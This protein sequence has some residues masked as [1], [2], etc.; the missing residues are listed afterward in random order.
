MSRIGI[1][2]GNGKFPFLALQGARSLGH[3]VTVVAV[4]VL[5]AEMHSVR[6]EPLRQVG[7]RPPHHAV[8]VKQLARYVLEARRRNIDDQAGGDRRGDAA[9]LVSTGV[10]LGLALGGGAAPR[11]RSRNGHGRR[12]VP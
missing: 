11:R 3:D 9:S 8:F 6:A 10:L 2:A 4:T 5:L 7:P 1:V 12:A